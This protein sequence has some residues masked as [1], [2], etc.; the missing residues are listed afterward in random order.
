MLHFGTVDE[1][2]S[3][4]NVPDIRKVL[5]K[6]A[7]EAQDEGTKLKELVGAKYMGLIS[8]ADEA[9]AMG[10]K[11]EQLEKQL[12]ALR[13]QAL[14]L[15][16]MQP[17][18]PTHTVSVP[19]PEGKM[20]FFGTSL[21]EKL[22]EMPQYLM[23]SE[24][25]DRGL[26][27]NCS[28]ELIKA[29]R[30]W[31]PSSSLASVPPQILQK[32][33][34]SQRKRLLCALKQVMAQSIFGIHPHNQNILY[35]MNLD[36]LYSKGK[37]DIPF[38]LEESKQL[39][40]T[41][42]D[43]RTTQQFAL[44]ILM[45][46]T[47][48]ALATSLPLTDILGND[49][50]M[51]H[52]FHYYDVAVLRALEGMTKDIYANILKSALL[53]P[54]KAA[55]VS[56]FQ[57]EA[58]EGQS[59]A[60]VQLPLEEKYSIIAHIFA[61]VVQVCAAFLSETSLTDDKAQFLLP[62]AILLELFAS[63]SQSHVTHKESK[64]NHI[65]A[66]FRQ[67]TLSKLQDLG[68]EH[69]SALHRTVFHWFQEVT[70]LITEEFT[71]TIRNEYFNHSNASSTS[72]PTATSRS[73][74]V[75]FEKVQVLQRSLLHA[76]SKLE[77]PS[78]A[79]SSSM[80]GED[81][82]NDIPTYPELF[83]LLQSSF[84]L[85]SFNSAWAYLSSGKGMQSDEPLVS[86]T[87]LFQILFAKPLKELLT[88]LSHSAI[89][90]QIDQIL[91]SMQSATSHVC[92]M[93]QSAALEVHRNPTKRVLESLNFS[94]SGTETEETRKAR[95][96]AR[97]SKLRQ[98]IDAHYRG[99]IETLQ[100]LQNVDDGTGSI[101]DGGNEEA[102]SQEPPTQEKLLERFMDLAA[103]SAV[104]AKLQTLHALSRSNIP[105]KLSALSLNISS[106]LLLVT[107]G[108]ADI[109]EFNEIVPTSHAIKFMN[110]A[111]LRR[112]FQAFPACATA[113][114]NK[115]TW[116]D[117]ARRTNWRSPFSVSTWALCDY[118]FGAL[119]SSF[120]NIAQHLEVSDKNT[121]AS[122]GHSNTSQ[123]HETSL[124]H[125]ILRLEHSYQV[126]FLIE[127]IQP[128]LAFFKSVEMRCEAASGV[129]NV[130]PPNGTV[131]F[132]ST[133]DASA[134]WTRGVDAMST[135]S[136]S[137]A[138][139]LISHFSSTL[140]HIV[141]Q[142]STPAPEKSSLNVLTQSFESCA[143]KTYT[144]FGHGL[145]KYAS[146]AAASHWKLPVSSEAPAD[147]GKFHRSFWSQ[148]LTRQVP[149]WLTKTSTLSMSK[150]N[151]TSKDA[152][153]YFPGS[154]SLGLHAALSRVS[155][156]IYFSG[157][158]DAP[159]LSPVTLLPGTSYLPDF[160]RTC[161]DNGTFIHVFALRHTLP[162]SI[163]F[164]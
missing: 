141:S 116:D 19:E 160:I 61:L 82:Q 21:H 104:K 132:D 11:S 24:L 6:T 69:K 98:R 8:S 38:P 7:K 110:R 85:L 100:R 164:L 150:G 78:S 154:V 159:L 49:D 50:A 77:N 131:D 101:V 88:D 155:F 113:L 54:A 63:L 17:S 28:I 129:S 68:A 158:L 138:F 51:D 16:E 34:G 95:L 153:P 134:F 106:F 79:S 111:V 81:V 10:D 139:L 103:S 40:Q 39:L 14:Q 37:Y 149:L 44:E 144:L 161:T 27:L 124:K 76:C 97:V 99:D 147:F 36:A 56:L 137:Y 87:S 65:S 151:D 145:A 64:H 18:F 156:H 152:V 123:E 59:R 57:N 120:V 126:Q 41:G 31:L 163:C 92:I 67:Q 115:A 62:S 143:T 162:R 157:L 47:V 130:I 112:T 42:E 25:L 128:L 135:L 142:V 73:D 22:M 35:A 114:F 80:N 32:Q 48:L 60:F 20:P 43:K 33:L 2:F 107:A 53:S 15:F 136:L 26:Y 148:N 12:L 29:T 119:S 96:K 23:I 72:S 58:T 125:R 94:S 45:S 83:R 121:F 74:V 55:I 118:Y 5:I 109:N 146:E 91:K 93:M 75:S 140:A 117:C 90:T 86:A 89:G 46:F 3:T 133:S 108:I 4:L 71:H 9:M 105:E 84:P 13:K 30:P 122:V 66:N 127:K 52:D 102:K 1:L 70:S